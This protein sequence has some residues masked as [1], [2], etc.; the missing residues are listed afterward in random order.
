MNLSRQ[1]CESGPVK[2]DAINRT[3]ATWF[4]KE[5]LRRAHTRPHTPHRKGTPFG[6]PSR[7]ERKT[8]RHEERCVGAGRPP[9]EEG[10][11][12]VLAA[13]MACDAT[14]CA[15]VTVLSFAVTGLA[16]YLVGI[17][18]V[19]SPRVAHIGCLPI[20]TCICPVVGS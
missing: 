15:P 11:N 18:Q 5:M 8:G 16:V 1:D 13:F 9:A 2:M 4:L 7:R 17:L 6:E 19:P 20:D 12:Q 3:A 10:A 14:A